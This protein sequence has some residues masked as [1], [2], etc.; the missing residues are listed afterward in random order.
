MFCVVTVILGGGGA[1][2]VEPETGTNWNF[3]RQCTIGRDEKELK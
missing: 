1:V 2:F 3:P